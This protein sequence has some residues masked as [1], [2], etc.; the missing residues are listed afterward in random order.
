MAYGWKNKLTAAHVTPEA[1]FWNRRQIM[2]GMAAAGAAGSI[3]GSAF[4]AQDALVPNS[5]EDITSYNN[6][7]EFGT[8][9]ERPRR[10]RR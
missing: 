9:K 10:Q 4:A 8:G 2:A 6:F 5:F 7:Y 3:A 1:A